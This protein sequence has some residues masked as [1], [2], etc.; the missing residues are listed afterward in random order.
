MEE[1]TSHKHNYKKAD[2]AIFI[3]NKIN[4][5]IE[6]I[7]KDKEKHFINRKG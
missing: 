5:K 2:V 3:P 7:T 4:L 6:M 1:D